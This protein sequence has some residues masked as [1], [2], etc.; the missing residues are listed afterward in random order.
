MVRGESP[1]TVETLDRLG[2]FARLGRE[3]PLP[4]EF[5][6]RGLAAS[7]SKIVSGPDLSG[8]ERGGNKPPKVGKN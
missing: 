8:S 1:P 4:S 7:G 5:T 6:D 3:V 2:D